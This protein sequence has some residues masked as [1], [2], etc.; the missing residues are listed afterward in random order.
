LLKSSYIKL[1]ACSR[2]RTLNCAPYAELG[3]DY[4]RKEITNVR[5]MRGQMLITSLLCTIGDHAKLWMLSQYCPIAASTWSLKQWCKP[6]ASPNGRKAVDAKVRMHAAPTL[7]STAI[8]KLPSM[9][10][11]A[12]HGVHADICCHSTI[13]KRHKIRTMHLSWTAHDSGCCV[14]SSSYQ[15]SRVLQ[16]AVLTPALLQ[17]SCWRIIAAAVPAFTLHL[18]CGYPVCCC[19]S[20]LLSSC[21]I[22]GTSAACT[23]P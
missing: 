8:V 22:A 14:L 3:L 12:A 13:T 18:S 5:H 2:Y 4:A 19:F 7:L 6:P 21:F 11:S 10:P 16:H 1:R 20:C 17:H 15:L 23:S 9:L